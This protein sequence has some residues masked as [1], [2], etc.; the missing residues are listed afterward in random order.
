MLG[1]AEKKEKSDYMDLALLE[2]RAI[3]SNMKH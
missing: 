2:R 3:D 1:G